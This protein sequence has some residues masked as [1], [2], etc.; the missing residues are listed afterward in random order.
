MKISYRLL[1]YFASTS[2]LLNQINPEDGGVRFFR[3]VGIKQ[4]AFTFQNSLMQ[5]PR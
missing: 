4:Y 2:S 1:G 3:N 5:V